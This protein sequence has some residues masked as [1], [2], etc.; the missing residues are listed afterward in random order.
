MFLTA[1]NMDI[2][3]IENHYTAKNLEKIAEKLSKP[4][5]LLMYA[6]MEAIARMIV[7]ELALCTAIQTDSKLKKLADQHLY[8]ANQWANYLAEQKTKYR[9]C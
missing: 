2:K 6:N 4:D 5:A 8:R 1:N 7:G 9:I 3:Q